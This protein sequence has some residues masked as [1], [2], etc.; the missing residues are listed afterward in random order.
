VWNDAAVSIGGAPFASS[1]G[2]VEV[3]EIE[4]GA[5]RS[6]LVMLSDEP[7]VLRRFLRLRVELIQ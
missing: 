4:D 1:T 6:V 7:L 5:L 3:S 2:G